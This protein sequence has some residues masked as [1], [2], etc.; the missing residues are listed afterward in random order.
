MNPDKSD[1]WGILSLFP[2]VYY[3]EAK[4]SPPLPALG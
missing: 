3:R 2:L 1:N 4:E